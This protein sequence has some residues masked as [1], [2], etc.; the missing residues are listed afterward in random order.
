MQ[1][2]NQKRGSKPQPKDKKFIYKDQM[3][4]SDVAKG[5]DVSP[6]T[7]I[8][9][10]ITLGI[11]SNVNQILDREIV[12]LLVDDFGFTFEIEKVTDITRYDEI[13]IEE[14][15]ASLVKRPPIVTVMGHVDHGK[16]TL[17]D[18]I[19]KARVAQGEAGGITQH[20]GAYQVKRKGSVITFIDTPGHAAFTQMRARGA[21][22]TDIVILV[23][24]ADDGVMPQTVE[25]IDHA[26]AAKVPLIV[27]INKMDK[28]SANPERVM[29][30]LSE[31]GV[32]AEA[33]GGDVPFVQVS[34]LKH[35]GI[36]ELLDV[37]E[38]VSEI[39]ELKANPNRLAVGSVIESRLDRGRGPVA[40]IIVE[41]GTLKVG[42][43]FVI[44]STFGRIRTIH[45]D[46]GRL[47]KQATPSQPVEITGLNDVPMAGDMLMVFPDEKTARQIA[48]ERQHR[49]REGQLKGQKRTLDSMFGDMAAAEKELNLI[50]KVDVQ[51]S[52]E[53]LGGLLEK[54]NI[55][56]FHVNI[57]RSN[58]GAITENDIILAEASNAI[59]IGFNV[60]PTAAVRSLA[61]E[62]G[63][64]IRLYSVIYKVQED[65][66]A[67]LQG[68]LEPEFEEKVIGQAE[69]RDI[70]KISK[71]GTIAG[72]FVTDG[73]IERDSLVR[74]I[75]ESIVVYEGKLASL[76]RFKDD[77]KSV[78][79]GY[80]CGISI[81]NYNDI[82][83][84]DIIEASKMKEVV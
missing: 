35:Q 44:G 64:E 19:R 80:E 60:R 23:V 5:L 12:E 3:N 65:I 77:V 41:H 13:E 33:W 20:I 6:A 75:R 25:A 22:V 10:L 61:E 50:I 1:N 18:S 14:D 58:V 55:Q 39:E 2:K 28:P 81:V 27:A 63:I 79:S 36:D 32:M 66:I 73:T 59:I 21:K 53:A 26:K 76:K 68:M 70:F 4:V 24:A 47:V 54:I 38:L 48:E 29:T 62:K 17:L 7:L 69:V 31:R 74:V 8:K 56:G 57:V 83:V 11:M 84:G 46:L 15:P 78:R 49:E 67:A 42:D 40:T 71:V 52:T 34:A 9:K 37:I 30:A 43:N 16:T 72:C 82:K 45:D 51:G